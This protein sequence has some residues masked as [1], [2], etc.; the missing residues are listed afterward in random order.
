MIGTRGSRALAR[1]SAV[2]ALHCACCL[3]WAWSPTQAADVTRPAEVAGL[4]ADRSGGDVGLSWSAVTSDAL[5]RPETIGQYRIYRGTSAS[6]VP[7]IAGGSNRIG[8]AGTAQFTDPGAAGDA[9]SYFYLITAVDAAGNESASKP[10]KVLHP[11]VLSGSWTETTIDLTWT[12]AQPSGE[13]AGYRLYCGLAS[14]S[15]ETVID[16]GLAT[17][18]SLAGL[19]PWVNWYCAVTALDSLGNE[20][21]FSNEHVD[22]VAGRVRVRAHD[23]DGLCWLSGGAS[24][25]PRPGTI[26]RSDGFQLL[27]PTDF[28]EGAWTRVQVTLTMDSRLCTP[29]AHGTV[30]KCSDENPGGTTRAA[31]HG[32]ASRTSSSS[33]TTASRAGGAASRTRIS[34]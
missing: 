13:V 5:G 19:A 16:V 18:R 21:A 31:T 34:S 1:S 20:S 3:A 33:S 4:G 27:V 8:T 23:D 11:P 9:A 32:T 30:N 14:R 25:P 7:D 15:Y 2:L 10:S 28:P 6:F 12:T 29:P 22:A 24:C 17:S 26:Q